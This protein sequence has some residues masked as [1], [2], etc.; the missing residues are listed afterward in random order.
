M[1]C[2]IQQGALFVLL[3]LCFC[4]FVFY[5]GNYMDNL[6]NLTM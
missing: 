4:L 6:K 2:E 5:K 1:Q 3:L